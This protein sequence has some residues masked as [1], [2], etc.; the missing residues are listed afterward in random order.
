MTNPKTNS[1][2]DPEKLLAKLKAEESESTRGKLKIFLGFAAGVGK[3][4]SMLQAAHKLLKNGDDVV[5]GC[6]VTHGRPETEAL[7]SGLPSIPL[8]A[9]QYKGVIGTRV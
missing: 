1:R 6:V 4:Y 7:L 2:P 9:M 3:T 5:A 8:K